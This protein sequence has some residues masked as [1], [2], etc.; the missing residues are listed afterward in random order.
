MKEAEQDLGQA[1]PNAPEA[2]SRFA[3]LIG[4]WRCKAKILVGDGEWQTFEASWVGRFML[5]G[6]V[7]ADE[8]RMTS[9]SGEL[10]V[11]GMNFRAYDPARQTWNMKWLNSRTGTWTDLGSEE[12]GGV[13]FEAESIVYALREPMAAHAYTRAT[14]MNISQTHFT[15]LGE[16]SEDGEAWSEFMRVECE[17]T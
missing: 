2:L 7:I 3:F 17:R 12:M 6:Y 4:R 8:Y 15:W 9:S 13:R 1:N 5:D 10:M 14:Y 11:L 16:S